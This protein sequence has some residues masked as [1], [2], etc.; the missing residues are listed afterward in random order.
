MHLGFN[1]LEEAKHEIQAVTS[2]DL[3]ECANKYFTDED[4][5]LSILKP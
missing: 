4:Y 2:E 1:F 5:V 3:R